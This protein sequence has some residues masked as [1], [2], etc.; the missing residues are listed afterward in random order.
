LLLPEMIAKVYFR[1]LHDGSNDPVLRAVT[2]QIE[3]DE[4]GH[5]AFHVSYLHRAFENMPF[6]RRIAIQ[7]VWRLVYRAACV[8]VIG[9]HRDLLRALRI[10]PGHFWHECGL[11][12]DAVA[13]AIFQ[14]SRM[15]AA[16]SLPPNLQKNV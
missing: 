13:A 4:D 1:A 2:E 10:R 14:P 12:F 6:G 7:V 3:R 5:L 9:D 15:L 11:I 16:P 8:V